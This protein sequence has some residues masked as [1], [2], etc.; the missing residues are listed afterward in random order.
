MVS[1][2][3]TVFCNVMSCNLA[4]GTYILEEPA[5]SILR[6]RHRCHRFLWNISTIYQITWHSSLKNKDLNFRIQDLCTPDPVINIITYTVCKP[7]LNNQRRIFMKLETTDVIKNYNTD[8]DLQAFTVAVAPMIVFISYYPLCIISVLH[9]F[10]G[11][12]CLHLQPKPNSVTL[13]MKA[14]SSSETSEQTYDSFHC[15]IPRTSTR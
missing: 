13:K 11:T 6:I 9:H 5:A 7:S 14:A 2:Q 4:D 3:I 15:N 8:I 10:K 12:F 1:I